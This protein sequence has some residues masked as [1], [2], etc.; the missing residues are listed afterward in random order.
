MRR[1]AHIL[2]GHITATGTIVSLPHASD[3]SWRHY[4]DVI[5]SPMASQMTSLTIVYTTVYSDTDQRKHPSSAS[6][7]FVREIHRRPMNSP[8]KGPVTRKLFPFDDIIMV[9][10]KASSTKPKQITATREMTEA[11]HTNIVYLR[12]GYDANN[13]IQLVSV[14]CILSS[15]F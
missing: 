15:M 6:L 3:V 11:F 2:Q 10:V 1:P 5:M 9:W 8:H 13:H 12:W 7:A 4:S 14:E